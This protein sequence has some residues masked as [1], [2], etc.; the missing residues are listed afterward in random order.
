MFTHS[1]QNK[2]SKLAR[3]RRLDIKLVRIFG[4]MKEKKS[5]ELFHDFF[6]PMESKYLYSTV[7]VEFGSGCEL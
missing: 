4:E 2:K 3:L 1:Q 7:G 6:R 5:I